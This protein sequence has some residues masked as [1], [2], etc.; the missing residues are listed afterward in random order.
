[1][2]ELYGS[3]DEHG[4]LDGESEP[5]PGAGSAGVAEAGSERLERYHRVGVRTGEEP[6][7][8]NRTQSRTG[9]QGEWRSLQ[10]EEGG[11]KSGERKIPA[12]QEY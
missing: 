12:R 1:M 6:A 3:Q 2:Q 10:S 7:R 5:E 8:R 9:D 4:V 11:K